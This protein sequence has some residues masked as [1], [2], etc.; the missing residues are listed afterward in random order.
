ML[1]WLYLQVPKS[2]LV[3]LKFLDNSGGAKDVDIKIQLI[4]DF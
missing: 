4:V 1:A 2:G 3:I